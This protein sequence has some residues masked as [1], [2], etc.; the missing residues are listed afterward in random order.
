MFDLDPSQFQTNRLLAAL[1]TE[2]YQRLLPSLEAIPFQVKDTLYERDQPI[3][4]VYFPLSGMASILVVLDDDT[5]IEAGIAGSEGMVGLPVFFGA[6]TA[7]TVSFYQIPGIAVR[8]RSD[9][10]RAEIGR[11]SA[12]VSILQGYAQAHFT[13]LSQNIACNSQHT[14]E[15][16]C[17]RWLLFTYDRMEKNEFLL[18][19]E[20]LSQMLGVRR[21]GVS[22]AMGSLQKAGYVHYRRGLI[23]ILDRAGLESVAC[24]CYAVVAT[25][26]QQM[27]KSLPLSDPG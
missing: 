25:A 23:T 22:V 26:Y 3:E 10:F 21:A 27:L 24:Q 1:P 15:Q 13:M 4:Y 8:M 2:D 18:T 11:N 9:L 16:R 12:L 20:F 17:A 19:Q 5:Y 14:V 6:K 7:P